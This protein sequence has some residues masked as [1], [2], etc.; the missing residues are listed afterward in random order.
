MGNVD[1]PVLGSQFCGDGCPLVSICIPAFNSQDKLNDCLDSIAVQEFRDFEVVVVDDGSQVPIELDNNVPEGLDGRRVK[2]VRQWNCGAY[3]ARQR[4]IEEACGAYIFCVDSDD[5]LADSQ[6][7]R[8]IAEA[9]NR[10][11]YPDV[12]IINVVREDGKSCFDYSSL[13]NGEI[14][15][16]SGTISLFFSYPGWNSMSSIVFRRS[17]IKPSV[18]CPRLLMAEDGLQKAEVLANA[19]TFALLDRPLYLYRENEGS[20]IT[21]PFKLSDF[22]DRV[23]VGCEIRKLLDVLD[24]TEE[25]WA[26]LFNIN[27]SASLVELVRDT[28]YCKPERFRLYEEFRGADGCEEALAFAGSGLP[29][30]DQICL[31][32]FRGCRWLLLD[33]LLKGRCLASR[34]KN[35]L[36]IE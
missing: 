15:S 31:L 35:A 13:G 32:V 19:T 3:A 22:Y 1:S 24:A 17:L 29:K 4:A 27:L 10:N 5:E 18:D 30:K 20:T 25:M 28:R 12:L 34:I 33:W 26:C 21:S 36:P 23:Y 14:V 16:R 11:S 8:E 7:L 6:V 2:L 9:L